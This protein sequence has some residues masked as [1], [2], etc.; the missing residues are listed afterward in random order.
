MRILIALILLFCSCGPKVIV[1]R[2]CGL[3][4]IPRYKHIIAIDTVWNAHGGVVKEVYIWVRKREAKV[5]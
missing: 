4:M 2:Q 3:N 1:K 5:P